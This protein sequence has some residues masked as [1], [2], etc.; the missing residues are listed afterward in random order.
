[1]R[2]NI[3]LIS[4]TLNRKKVAQFQ[5]KKLLVGFSNSLFSS[6]Q[7]HRKFPVQAVL[8]ILCDG[9]LVGVLTIVIIMS[10]IAL[11]SQYLWTKSF[12]ELELIRDLN[13]R[14]LESTSILESYL[15]KNQ[16]LSKSLVPTKAEDLIYVDRPNPQNIRSLVKETLIGRLLTRISSTPI[17]SGY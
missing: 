10:S 13:L 7:I 1:M 8:H 6:R 4:H 17:K 16:N 11:H 15:L 12:T 14:L 2:S 9:A 5:R 3:D